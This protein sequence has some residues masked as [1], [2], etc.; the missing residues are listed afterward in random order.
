MGDIADMML[1]GILCTSC[2]VYLD[3]EDARIAGVPTNCDKC[4]DEA[5]DE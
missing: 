3:D 4:S 5:E 1:E 2:G